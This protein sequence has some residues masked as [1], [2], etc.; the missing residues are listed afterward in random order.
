MKIILKISMIC[1]LLLSVFG[2]VQAARKYAPGVAMRMA[3]T[4]DFDVAESEQILAD[5]PEEWKK[6]HRA[7]VRQI[8]N[9][10]RGRGVVIKKTVEIDPEK[11]DIDELADKPTGKTS[12][13][14]EWDERTEVVVVD[15]KDALTS[16]MQALYEE[17]NGSYVLNKFNYNEVNK[18]LINPK[19]YADY[20]SDLIPKLNDF[21]KFVIRFEEA[22]QLGDGSSKVLL[23]TVLDK[24]S[25]VSG[26]ALLWK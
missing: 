13:K 20:Y 26:V 16:L 6:E 7:I 4:G 10:T 23:P 5:I 2:T 18:Y 8:E 19:K 17:K 15:M 1:G 3:T 12:T 21:I 11:E 24:A 25:A 14:E 9:G 22:N